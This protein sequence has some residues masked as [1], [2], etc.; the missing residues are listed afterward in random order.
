MGLLVL[1]LPAKDSPNASNEFVFVRTFPLRGDPSWY[2][3][4]S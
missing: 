1:Y 3:F 4:S 2:L